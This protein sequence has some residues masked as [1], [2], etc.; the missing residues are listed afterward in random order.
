M[1]KTRAASG[2][3]ALPCSSGS[4]RHSNQPDRVA[5]VSPKP[6]TSNHPHD[7]SPGQTYAAKIAAAKIANSR[8]F[9][10]A[11]FPTLLVT[12]ALGW[13]Q[14]FFPTPRATFSQA[15]SPCLCVDSKALRACSG[16]N[17]KES[18]ATPKATSRCVRFL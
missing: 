3:H 12:R 16:V 6:P 2:V 9:Q 15:H 7:G 11:P 13:P 8:V 10:R 5:T 1:L 18:N 14:M 4:S 17:A